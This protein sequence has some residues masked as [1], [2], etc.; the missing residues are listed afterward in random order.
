MATTFLV[1]T[2]LVSVVGLYLAIARIQQTRHKLL[3]G[4]LVILLDIVFLK[5]AEGA[6][7]KV[8]WNEIFTIIMLVSLLTSIF[9]TFKS[10]D[11]KGRLVSLGLGA[12]VLVAVFG[13]ATLLEVDN[14]RGLF[15]FL[16][17][18]GV[19]AGVYAL[20]SLGLNIHWGYT[21]LFNIGVAAFFGV[22]AYTSAILVKPPTIVAVDAAVPLIDKATY[23]GLP[24]LAGIAGAMIVSGIL[25][26]LIGALTLRLREDYLAIA[27][28]G[29]SETIRLIAT[30]EA[31]LTEGS[32]GINRIP[33]PLRELVVDTLGITPNYYIWVYFVLVVVALVIFYFLLRKIVSSP[34]GRVLKAIR[35]DE[36][37]AMALGKN[38]FSFKLQSLVVGA[39]IMGAAGSLFVHSIGTVGP[40]IINPLE[41]TF[42]VWVML[43]V[44]GAGNNMGAIFGAIFIWGVWSGTG[45]LG[46]FLPSFVETPW[47]DIAFAT[48]VF[49]PL[50]I[51]AIAVIFV[52]VLLY[53]SKGLLGEKKAQFDSKTQS[54]SG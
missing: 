43:I 22:G 27:T 9:F 12:A 46:Q 21:G 52:F 1:L 10:K 26:L 5:I 18:F 14:I 39:M 7:L 23:F 33:Q 20:L 6:G 32:V 28:I 11:M 34:W 49:G 16:I 15:S 45:F 8:P 24:F 36:D 48:R 31:W 25:A 54:D 19:T 47:G 35:E 44:G 51:I 41:W 2:I 50:R 38:T 29:I 42:I 40:S 4:A 3:T 37:A 17:T 53:R 13:I 30:N